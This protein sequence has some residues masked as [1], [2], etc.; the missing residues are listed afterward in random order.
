M[1]IGHYEVHDEL[2]RGG[3]GVVFRATDTRSGADVVVKL[4]RV[5]TEKARRRLAR[6]ADAMR[7]LK[8]PSVV[9]LYDLG[10]HQGQ[11]YLVL[12]YV[13]G[14]SLDERLRREG[15]LPLEEA[16]DVALQ[17]G[18]ALQACH[19]L[20][21]LHRDVK[22]GNVLLDAKLP[23]RVKLTD[24]GLVKDTDP[25][26]TRSAGLTVSGNLLG[27]PGYWPPEQARGRLEEI[28]PPSD[29]YALG[30]LIY[31]L[32]SG[33]P[34]RPTGALQ[35]ALDAFATP[36]A[37]LGERAPA[38]L[39]TLVRRCLESDPAERPPLDTVL[40]TLSRQRDAPPRSGVPLTLLAGGLLLALLAGGVWLLLDELRRHSAAQVGV[41]GPDRPAQATGPDAPAGATGPDEN[42][43]DTLAGG[44][45]NRGLGLLQLQ[46]YDEAREAFD[47]VLKLAPQSV[48]AYNGRAHCA[49]ELH[50]YHA[51][52]ADFDRVVELGPKTG[53]DYANRGRTYGKLERH[54]EAIADLRRA[55]ELGPNDGMTHADLGLALSMLDRFDEALEHAERAIELEPNDAFPYALRGGLQLVRGRYRQAVA[56]IDRAFELGLSEEQQRRYGVVREHAAERLVEQRLDSEPGPAR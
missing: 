46:R 3:M 7:R 4:L 33:E 12:P 54:H 24:F 52:L 10:E 35:R 38:W 30:A 17:I 15:A 11:P 42:S 2:A 41:A 9:T 47:R 14:D 27:T 25:T 50:D 40:A 36:V 53:V 5:D 43:A 21:L 19:A 22:P 23:G 31:A 34:P 49:F 13:E 44:L 48:R 56:D 20:G 28:G 6:E 51:A 8:H 55:L 39:D 18:E 26:P 1:R 45:L 16:L 29:V 37:P 32:V